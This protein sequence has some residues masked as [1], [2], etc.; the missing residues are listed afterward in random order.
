ML[1]GNAIAGLL[2]DFY[3]FELT[4]A[5]TECAHCHARKPIAETEVYLNA[6]GTVVRCR[7]CRSVLMVL[8]TVNGTT[9]V[10]LSGLSGLEPGPRA[11]DPPDTAL[12]S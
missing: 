3:G 11:L 1:D 2:F 8:L 7:S 10:D 9:C 4:S 12:A 6:P 5:T